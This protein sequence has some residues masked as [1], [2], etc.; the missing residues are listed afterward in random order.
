MNQ[1][2]IDNNSEDEMHVEE[3]RDPTTKN[4][5]PAT[6]TRSFD[7]YGKEQSNKKVLKTN[8]QQ[9]KTKPF[10]RKD[11]PIKSYQI[12]VYSKKEQKYK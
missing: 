2:F 9:A 11:I 12:D 7:N 3:Q 10:E 8:D 4:K 6:N 5:R 1:V